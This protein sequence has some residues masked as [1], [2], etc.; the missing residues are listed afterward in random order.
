MEYRFALIVATFTLVAACGG[1]GGSDP[2]KPLLEDLNADGRLIVV[3]FG[4]SITRGVGDG[5]RSTSIGGGYP[6]RVGPLLVAD[7]LTEPSEPPLL[8]PEIVNRG[9]PG[10]RMTEGRPRLQR[11][12]PGSGADYVILLEGINDIGERQTDRALRILPQMVGD[13]FANGAVP[14]LGTLPP[15]CCA[16]A[17]QAP[18]SEIGR[19]NGAIIGLAQANGLILVDFNVG[20]IVPPKTSFDPADGLIHAPEGLHPTPRGYDAMAAA[21]LAGLRVGPLLPPPTPRS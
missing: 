10:E 14:I 11:T 3:A 2:R 8:T 6:A 18:P 21:V 7:E 5:A 16:H 20:F 13:V 9:V 12:L 1:G 15:T 19:Y 17:N 4:D